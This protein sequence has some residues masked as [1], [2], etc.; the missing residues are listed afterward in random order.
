[1]EWQGKNRIP[2]KVVQCMVTE[3]HLEGFV[4]LSKINN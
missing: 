2:N 4:K 3:S 1:M